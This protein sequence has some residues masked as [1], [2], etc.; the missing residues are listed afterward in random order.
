MAFQLKPIRNSEEHKAALQRFEA[1]ISSAEGTE[2][3]Y[4]R[5]ILA[6]L[7]EKYEDESI[8]LPLPSPVEAIKFRLEQAGLTRKDLEPILGGRAK[9]SEIL[10]GKRELTLKMARGLHTQLGIPAESLLGKAAILDDMLGDFDFARVPVVE[11]QRNGAFRNLGIKD[12]KAEAEEAIRGL[13]SLIGGPQAIPVGLFRKTAS[14]RLNAKL[15]SYA[16]SGWCLQVLAEAS[17]VDAQPYQTGSITDEFLGNLVRLSAQ[18]TG[19][20]LAQE[21]LRQIGVIL[22]I[23]P[24]LK[25]TYLDGAAFMTRDGRPV[26]G[27]TLR[28]DKV[29]NFWFALL[30]ELG[31]LVLHL[32]RTHGGYLVDDLSLR[33]S[34][35]D[36]EKE[37]QAD[38][39]AERHLLP[40]GFNLDQQELVTT[41]DVLTYAH[42]HSIAPAIVAG[43]IQYVKQNYRL[44][45]NLLGRGEVSPVFGLANQAN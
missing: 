26:V 9:V 12:A 34:Q 43:R 25:N 44:F 23:V 24:H 30:H 22:V 39:F 40:K 6:I 21:A 17:L 28:Y 27:L 13:V 16:L 4:Q 1:L 3:A 2:E 41:F 33:G 36:D 29:D 10:S 5:D 38:T 11:M 14:A 7:I 42:A 19:P 20:K 31:H 18:K 35:T 45:A 32:E 37:K 15:N 8:P